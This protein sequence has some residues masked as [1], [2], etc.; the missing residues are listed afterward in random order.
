ML[1]LAP[2]KATVVSGAAVPAVAAL[3]TI[4]ATTMAVNTV[5]IA[6]MSAT[7]LSTVMP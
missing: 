7:V 6:A 2:N 5:Q 3:I 1:F 4:D